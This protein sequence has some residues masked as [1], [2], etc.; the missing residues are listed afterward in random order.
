MAKKCRGVMSVQKRQEFGEIWPE[1]SNFPSTLSFMTLK[2]D[3]RFEEKLT[4]DLENDR[5]MANFH[6]NI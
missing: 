6:Q 5:N 1:H 4:F 3:A 2:S